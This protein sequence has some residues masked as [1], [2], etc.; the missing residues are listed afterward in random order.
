MLTPFWKTFLFDARVLIIRLPFGSTAVLF[1]P[2]KYTVGMPI[3]EA[4]DSMF[5]PFSVTQFCFNLKKHSYVLIYLFWGRIDSIDFSEISR[6]KITPFFLT[7]LPV[8]TYRKQVLH[9]L[10]CGISYTAKT[11]SKWENFALICC[12]NVSA[13]R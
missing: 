3:S 12:R 6:K 2:L 1:S 7:F 9:A 11:I 10:H 13:L 5:L 8:K 4:W